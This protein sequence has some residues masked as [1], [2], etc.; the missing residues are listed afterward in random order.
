M[1]SSLQRRNNIDNK[2]G[3]GRCFDTTSSTTRRT[4]DKH[5]NHHQQI[6][7][8]LQTCIIDCCKACR[9][10]CNRLK[11]RSHQL[12][13][14]IEISQCSGICELHQHNQQARY[15]NQK[16]TDAQYDFGMQRQRM[17]KLFKC[18]LAM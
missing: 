6:G 11:H 10:Q 14:N 18:N 16:Q 13:E 2:H 15:N 4:T 12:L 17:S 5:D 9:T 8:R 1:L 7:R 3:D